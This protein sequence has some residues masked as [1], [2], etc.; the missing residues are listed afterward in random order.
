MARAQFY[1]IEKKEWATLAG[2]AL[3]L[4]V[5]DATEGFTLLLWVA[6]FLRWIVLA[7][8]V[9]LMAGFL[10]VVVI[11]AWQD[12]R[13]EKAHPE[14]GWL[15]AVGEIPANEMDVKR[16]SE[17]GDPVRRAFPNYASEY[18]ETEEDV[19]PDAPEIH[20]RRVRQDQ[21]RRR[22]AGVDFEINNEK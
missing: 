10:V 19:R 9:A 22:G 8:T 16:L 20:A 4:L 17:E 15:G 13:D 5:L 3:A 6:G 21:A 18:L 11:H 1:A 7:A 12:K 2:L 14:K